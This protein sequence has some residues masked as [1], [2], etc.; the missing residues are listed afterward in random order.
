MNYGNIKFY[1]IANGEGI[2]VSL[3]VS[4][5]KFCC[6]DCFN[7]EAW[8][9]D[10]GKEF[11]YKAVMTIREGLEKPYIKGLSILGGDPLWQSLSG[12]YDLIHLCE[13]VHILYKKDI[14]MWSGFT[15]DTI[16]KSK[17]YAN[18]TDK[19]TLLAQR[20]LISSCDVFVDGPFKV[21]QKDLTLKWKGSSN[22]RVIDVKKTLNN[23]LNVILYEE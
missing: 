20:K 21:E 1:D 23:N 12:L 18:E 15:F 5:C 22:Q 11:D 14:W 4:G 17:V 8:D 2:R 16:F 10:Y 6:K 3:F 7:S 9:F 19:D 13:D